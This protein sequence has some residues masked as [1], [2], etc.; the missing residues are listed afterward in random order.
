VTDR[1]PQ[2][3]SRW[4]DLPEAAGILADIAVNPPKSRT[5]PCEG[6]TLYYKRVFVGRRVQ[7]LNS[8]CR[9]EGV[10]LL[11]ECDAAG[12]H[13][14]FVAHCE[15]DPQTVIADIIASA[16]RFRA[17]GAQKRKDAA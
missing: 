5:A 9:A 3:I 1:T 16:E 2:V 15:L 14:A 4:T 10:R 13:A 6:L 17:L 8:I 7:R 12:D 11:R